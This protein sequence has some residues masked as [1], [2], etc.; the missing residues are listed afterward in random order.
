M[1]KIRMMATSAFTRNIAGSIVH[2]DPEHPDNDGKFPVMTEE[3]AV[4]LLDAGLVKKMTAKQRAALDDGDL[5]AEDD[6][7][8]DDDDAGE[9]TGNVDGASTAGTGA[10]ETAQQVR[11][12]RTNTTTTGRGKN[13]TGRRAP[14]RGKAPTAGEKG[15]APA[16]GHDTNATTN[17]ATTAVSGDGTTSA[18]NEGATSDPDPD[19]PPTE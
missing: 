9:G 8:D 10:S 2:G 17:N 19:A 16:G 1:K 3:Q 12:R 11:D 7:D 4:L 18:T 6:D 14:A 15:G 13:Q 5:T